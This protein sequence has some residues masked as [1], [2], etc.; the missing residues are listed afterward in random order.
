MEGEQVLNWG[1]MSFL[2]L[3]DYFWSLCRL[4]WNIESSA[5]FFLSNPIFASLNFKQRNPLKTQNIRT[6]AFAAL[7]VVK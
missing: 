1:T 6:W 7:K 2:S 3:H 4:L 5:D